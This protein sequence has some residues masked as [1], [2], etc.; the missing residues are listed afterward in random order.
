MRW[1]EVPSEISHL[2]QTWDM[3]NR[4]HKGHLY[5]I[6]SDSVGYLYII[7]PSLFLFVKLVAWCLN[8]TP[9]CLEV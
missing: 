3:D 2:Q 4:G 8:K 1:R 6:Q 7:Y 5:A 9:L